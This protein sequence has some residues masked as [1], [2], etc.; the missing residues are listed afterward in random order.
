MNLSIIVPT[1]NRIY[2]LKKL[3]NYYSEL[4]YKGNLVILDSSD[5]NIQKEILNEIKL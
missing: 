4:N 3:L 5:Q 2:Y 1:K